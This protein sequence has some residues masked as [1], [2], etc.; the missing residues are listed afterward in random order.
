MRKKAPVPIPNN[1]DPQPNQGG[2]TVQCC[3]YCG[4]AL[5]YCTCPKPPAPKGDSGRVPD[6]HARYFRISAAWWEAY[7]AMVSTNYEEPVSAGVQAGLVAAF[8]E[9]GIDLNEE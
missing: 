8:K 9:A 1:P 7:R 3:K 5:V 4:N 6:P 2:G